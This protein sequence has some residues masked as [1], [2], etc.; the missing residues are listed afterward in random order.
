VTEPRRYWKKTLYLLKDI[1]DDLDV[2]QDI[3]V[4]RTHTNDM[5]VYLKVYMTDKEWE[6]YQEQDI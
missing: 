1:P 4:A 3:G 6:E 2:E 5:Q